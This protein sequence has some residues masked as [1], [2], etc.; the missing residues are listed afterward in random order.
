MTKKLQQLYGLKWNPFSPDVPTEALHVPARLD[1]FGWRVEQL[2]REGGFAVILGDPGTGKSVALRVL[3]ARL[4]LLRDVV[5]GI[6][7]RPHAGVADCYRE[8]GHL[9]GVSLSPHNRWAGAKALRETWRAHIEAARFRPVLL[10]DEAQDV[11]T[12]VLNELRLLASADLDARVILTVVLAGDRRLQ[13]RLREMELLPLESRLRVRLLLDTATRDDLAQCLRH[14]LEQA[15]AAS[16]STIAPNLIGCTCPC[17]H[18]IVRSRRLIVNADFGKWLPLGTVH[19]LH[20]ILPRRRRMSSTSP[21]LMYARSINN[22]SIA[23]SCRAK[24]AVN[25]GMASSS[26]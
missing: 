23:T 3:A 21:L 16:N 4:A 26:G 25:A 14:A 10:I 18:A 8:L 22:S 7:T 17:G 20:T 11:R 15:A 5:V 12:E 1:S 13:A 19:G 24:S 6:L 9:F 2:V